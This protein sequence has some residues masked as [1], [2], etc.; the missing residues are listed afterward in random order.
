VATPAPNS[1]GY[2]FAL[3]HQASNVALNTTP[4]MA[5]TPD[6]STLV[7][8][9][10]TRSDPNTKNQFFQ[11]TVD[12]AGTFS[13]ATEAPLQ[14]LRVS[15]PS[16]PGMSVFN[17]LLY[18]CSQQ[19]SNPNLL[20]IYTS[21]NNGASWEFVGN[22]TNVSVGGNLQMVTFENNLVIANQQNSSAHA[23]TILSSPN[24]TETGWSAKV[25]SSIP[26]LPHG[27]GIALFNGG[28][29]AA[30]SGSNGFFNET[31]AN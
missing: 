26:G 5:V 29:S 18:L 27:P 14:T 16:Q 1:V 25:Y 2:T 6:G 22:T 19:N 10:G 23:F 13:T 24:G 17:G 7:I 12:T 15:S 20:F 28:V 8:M 31:F 21:S 4:A 3:V 30:F 9:F 11:V